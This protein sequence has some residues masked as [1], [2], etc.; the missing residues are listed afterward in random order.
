MA[1]NAKGI[2]ALTYLLRSS[3]KFVH[4]DNTWHWERDPNIDGVPAK[5]ATLLR[6]G[7]SPNLEKSSY[8]HWIIHR[9][10]ETICSSWAHE[11][12]VKCFIAFIKGGADIYAIEN[13]WW[14]VTEIL[15][16]YRQGPTWEEAL[17]ACDFN[18]EE[19]YAKDHNRGALNST[20]IYAPREGR[21]RRRGPMHTPAYLTR[22][23]K[24]I[25][26]WRLQRYSRL[27]CPIL[28][29]NVDMEELRNL[30]ENDNLSERVI[31]TTGGWYSDEDEESGDAE[32]SGGVSVNA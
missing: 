24:E 22:E 29:R 14:S 8:F 2:N 3:L 5:I 12:I 18:V 20:D 17:E 23:G 27:A 6:H 4:G 31:P 16:Y 7:A 26:D 9:L 32:E 19:V 28:G 11:R 10:P 25:R 15:H 1:E 30:V 13:S 21:P